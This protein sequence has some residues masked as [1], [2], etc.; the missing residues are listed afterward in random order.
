MAQSVTNTVPDDITRLAFEDAMK[1]L[2]QIVKALE[3]GQVKLDEAVKAYERGAALKRHCEAKLADA[4]MK[5][6]KITGSG[7]N[8]G[9]TAVDTE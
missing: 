2:E 3:S 6:E 9:L 1:E 4:R 7:A 5:V 8:L